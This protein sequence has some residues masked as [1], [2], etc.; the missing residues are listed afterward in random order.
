MGVANILERAK[1]KVSGHEEERR[2]TKKGG[3]KA[4]GT[5]KEGGWTTIEGYRGPGRADISTKVGKKRKRGKKNQGLPNRPHLHKN[6]E[7]KKN[8]CRG[9]CVEMEGHHVLHKMCRPP[10]NTRVNAQRGSLTRR[11][12]GSVESER[13]QP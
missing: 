5:G 3:Q 4:P 6:K 9:D 1:E 11:A 13:I 7:K 8:G 2:S 10:T 12:E